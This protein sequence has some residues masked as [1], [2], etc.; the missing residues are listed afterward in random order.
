MPHALH[1]QIRQHGR[2]VLQKQRVGRENQRALRAQAVLIGIEQKGDAVQ[3]D[4][5][6]ART[7]HALHD[8]RA[9]ERM[10]D[11]GVLLGLDGGDDFREPL[12]RDCAQHGLQKLVLRGNAR[13]K[14]G[15]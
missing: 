2:D 7:R 11:D 4:A 9:V 5:G 1:A 15:L 3:G 13:I 6:F 12:S 8:Q 10:A 14:I